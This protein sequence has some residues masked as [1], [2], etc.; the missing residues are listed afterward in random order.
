MM[1]GIPVFCGPY[2]HNSQQ[3]CDTLC[4]E[5]ALYC[6][7]NIQDLILNLITLFEHP[8]IVSTQV[9]NATRVIQENQGV[10]RACFEVIQSYL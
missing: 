10:V 6:G 9:Q 2:M 4:A 1:A 7:S 3:I 5:K 8:D